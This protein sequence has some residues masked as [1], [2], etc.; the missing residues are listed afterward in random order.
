MQDK[1]NRTSSEFDPDAW[2]EQLL[3]L[4]PWARGHTIDEQNAEFVAARQKA[5]L[6]RHSQGKEVW[7]NWANDML[8]LKSAL[9]TTGQ[10][11]AMR[12]HTMSPLTREN[13]AKRI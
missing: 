11:A 8:A 3:A 10:W 4:N 13:E 7:N 1:P 6:A 2:R 5:T 12:G 9:Q